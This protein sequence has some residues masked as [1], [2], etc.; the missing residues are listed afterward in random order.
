MSKL[1]AAEQGELLALTKGADSVEMKLTVTEDVHR[2]LIF[3]L[4][5]LVI[6]IDH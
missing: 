2:S 6:S 1:T 3:E 5:L 4:P